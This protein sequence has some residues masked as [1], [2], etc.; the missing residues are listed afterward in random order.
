M[1]EARRRNQNKQQQSVEINGRL[2][3]KQMAEEEI[4][5]ARS[6]TGPKVVGGKSRKHRIPTQY[7]V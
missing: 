5:S 7:D 3:P 2:N 6:S 1:H 4:F